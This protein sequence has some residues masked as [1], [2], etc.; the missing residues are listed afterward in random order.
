MSESKYNLCSRA[1]TLTMPW[2]TLAKVYNSRHMDFLPTFVLSQCQSEE[3]KRN[4]VLEESS[5]LKHMRKELEALHLHNAELEKGAVQD[6]QKEI[7][8]KDLRT[9]HLVSSKV[10]KFLSQLDNSS[11]EESE[12]D[13]KTKG[14]GT[15]CRGV[16]TL[17]LSSVTTTSKWRRKTALYV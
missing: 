13:N 5:Q 11:S 9:N 12:D 1:C 8:L 4:K 2:Y 3:N 15:S 16:R 7:M 14:I 17:F 10:D 6:P